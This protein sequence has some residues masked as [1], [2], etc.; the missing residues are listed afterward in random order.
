MPFMK[1]VQT[2]HI[3]REPKQGI[4]KCLGISNLDLGITGDR[5]GAAADAAGGDAERDA[6]AADGAAALH[7]S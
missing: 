4:C 6:A 1:G 7:G 2:Q 5:S 3:V